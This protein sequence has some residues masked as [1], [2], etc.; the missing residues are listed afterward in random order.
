MKYVIDVEEMPKIIEAK[1]LNEAV[2]KAQ[3]YLGVRQMQK[4]EEE[5]YKRV[6]A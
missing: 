6:E 3:L 2:E 4:D 5:T 1:S